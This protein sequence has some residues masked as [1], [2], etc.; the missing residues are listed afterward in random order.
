MIPIC[1]DKKRRAN[2]KPVVSYHMRL[3]NCKWFLT[4]HYLY[5]WNRQPTRDE[6]KT[7]KHSK[8]TTLR[9]TNKFQCWAEMM[10]EELWYC[11]YRF[12]RFERFVFF[13]PKIHIDNVSRGSAIAVQKIPNS[14][15]LYCGVSGKL[16]STRLDAQDLMHYIMLGVKT[17]I[18]GLRIGDQCLNEVFSIFRGGHHQ[19]GLSHFL[20]REALETHATKHQHARCN[21]KSSVLHKLW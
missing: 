13:L 17:M 18:V 5:Y 15:R 19:F 16:A 14:T 8:D 1:S 7:L 6:E 9:Q 3:K 4:T 21:C 12:S 10:K 2:L 11:I 20:V